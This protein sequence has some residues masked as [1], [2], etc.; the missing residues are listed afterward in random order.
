[1]SYPIL[2][3]VTAPVHYPDDGW[4]VQA[5][6]A[7]SKVD[8]DVFFAHRQDTESVAYAKSVCE[9]CPVRVECAASAPETGVGIWGGSTPRTLRHR[10]SR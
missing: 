9:Q 2:S 1:M 6:C 3:Q 10:R 7:N 5:L 8:P 4:W